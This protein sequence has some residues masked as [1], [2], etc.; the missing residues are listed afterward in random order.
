MGL[1]GDAG[2]KEA[3]GTIDRNEDPK[4]FGFAAAMTLNYEH[5]TEQAENGA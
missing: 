3:N 1:P 2:Y 4:L 5:G